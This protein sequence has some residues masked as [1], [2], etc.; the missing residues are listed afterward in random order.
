MNLG[1]DGLERQPT[2]TQTGV[3]K[4]R[5][6]EQRDGHG[7]TMLN[8]KTKENLGLKEI[9]DNGRLVDDLKKIRKESSPPSEKSTENKEEIVEKNDEIDIIDENMIF[10]DDDCDEMREMRDVSF[11]R[12]NQN[13]KMNNAYFKNNTILD[14]T[15]LWN[16]QPKK[17]LGFSDG[18]KDNFENLRVHG[19]S[20]FE[21]L[22]RKKLENQNIATIL[23]TIIHDKLPTS[24][25][26]DFKTS[27][28]KDFAEIIGC[29]IDEFQNCNISKIEKRIGE[30]YQA[31]LEES[32][33]LSSSSSCTPPI[34]DQ[35]KLI[36]IHFHFIIWYY[37]EITV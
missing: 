14:T 19:N 23:D 36:M 35:V 16:N 20:S 17:N 18:G 13:D 30:D 8:S 29:G 7:K 34:T 1:I 26:N 32:L 3:V 10:S 12:N 25:I 24:G 2:S 21:L 11:S 15:R 22:S 6:Q 28:K 37:S 5:P 9:N 27:T 4:K 33:P 31:N